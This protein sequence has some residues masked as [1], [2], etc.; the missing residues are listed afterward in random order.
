MRLLLLGGTAWLSR[1]LARDAVARGH[2]VTCAARGRSGPVP[3]GVESFTVDRDDPEALAPL[4]QR[5][6]DAVVDVTRRPSH[7]RSAVRVLGG[8]A[9]HWTYVSSISVYADS[10][11]TGQD[12]G[13]PLVEPTPTGGDESDPA[14]YAGHKRACELA[15]E[16]LPADLFIARPGLI[17]GPGDP[18][19]RFAYWPRRIAR[20]QVVVAP[21]SPEDPVQIVDVRDLAR[22]LVDSIE[23]R[24]TGTFDAVG[25]PMPMSVFLDAVAAGVRAH[26]AWRWA[27]HDDLTSLGI[28]PWTG[29]GSLPLW[30][31]H[32][33]FAGH[34]SR[35][36][37]VTLAAGLAPRPVADTARDTWRWLQA[38]PDAPVGGLTDAEHAALLDR[39]G[40]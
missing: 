34:M 33:E 36:P 21:G 27:A 17:V 8:R 23:A 5:T 18:S 37:S 24:R 32:P 38:T 3:A 26:P 9:A 15:V 29:P 6:Y 31:P 13:A 22:W 35:D 39:L 14:G 1:Q 7:A 28:E 25:E 12:I 30:V 11:T 2:R 40:P 19:G 4:A 20:D 16:T 10:A